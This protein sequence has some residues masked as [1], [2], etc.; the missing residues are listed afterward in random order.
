MKRLELFINGKRV[1]SRSRQVQ[2]VVDPSTQKILADVPFATNAEVD[3]AV[4]GAREAQAEWS[5]VPPLDRARL[6]MRYQDI[7][8][9]NHTA[10]AKVLS[11]DNGKTLEDA[12]GSVWRGIEVVEHAC[13]IATLLQGEALENLVPGVDSYMLPQPLGVCA[14]ITPF[15]FPA[16][17]PLWMFPMAL[18][19]GN[20]F[21]L[22]PSEQVPM[23]PMVLAE[24]LMEAGAPKGALQIVHGGKEQVDMLLTHPDIKAVS[25]VGSAPVGRH[26]YSLGTRHLKR[27]Q[28]LAGAK[29][30]MVIM[31]DADADK[32]VNALVGA[33]CGAAGQRCMAISVAVLVKGAK[34]ILSQLAAAMGKLRPGLWS[35]PK[36]DFGPLVSKTARERVLGL[37][38]QGRSEG[39]KCLLDGSSF[40]A[41]GYPDGNWVGPTLFAKVK[42]G[43]SIYEEEI[44]GPV[45]ACVEVD[46]LDGA[47]QLIAD[48]QYGNGTSIFTSSGAVAR[49]FA[50]SV[51]AGQVGI[52]IPV[53]VPPPYHSFSGWGMSFYGDMGAYGKEAVRFYTRNKKILSRWFDSDIKSSLNMTI[54]LK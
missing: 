44:F 16:M 38:R 13:S 29:N 51:D 19:C 11:R 20:T 23:T 17:I 24:L 25:F 12:K 30:H 26:V 53:P 32:A 6:M 31:P 21:V 46:T 9:R 37:I 48:N 42:P 54:A 1:Q 5:R 14:G 35:D 41:K 45:L 27:V 4:N 3:R 43:M 36:A 15:N 2:P 7:L 22:K 40:K 39:A 18:A 52:N 49:R 28:A 47:L 8:K 10:I 34:R 50:H 33:S